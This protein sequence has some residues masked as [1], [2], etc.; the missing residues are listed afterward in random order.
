[1]P[2][3]NQIAEYLPFLRRYARA[4]TGNQQ[5]GDTLVR[6]TLARAVADSDLRER[7]KGGRVALYAAF[8]QVWQDGGASARPG[9]PGTSPRE[10]A[11]QAHL[12]IVS[13]REREALLLTAVE[14]F[15]S[16]E[17]AA[18]M[19]V[20]AEEVAALAHAAASDIA[21]D[22]RRPCPDHRGRAADRDATRTDR[23]FA[24]TRDH[25]HDR[26]SQAG[27]RIRRRARAGTG[28]GRYPARRRQF[29]AGCGRRYSRPVAR[30][31]DHLHHPPI[32]KGY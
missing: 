11:A 19:G 1:M 3:G 32:P 6:S 2:L 27:D 15:T 24:G 8:T 16:A 13:P 7:L 26:D 5:R 4:L 18:I 9:A 21:R 25:R 28:A 17:A 12:A 29:R 14:E 31:A 30:C 23:R 22:N 10:A 20:T